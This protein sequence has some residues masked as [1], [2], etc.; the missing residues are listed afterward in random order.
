MSTVKVPFIVKGRYA[1]VSLKVS[2][3]EEGELL[4]SLRSNLDFDELALD[5]NRRIQQ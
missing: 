4:T 5:I 2:N 3:M 1:V